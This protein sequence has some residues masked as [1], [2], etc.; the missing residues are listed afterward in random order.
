MTEPSRAEF[1]QK[2]TV[3]QQHADLWVHIVKDFRGSSELSREMETAAL[4]VGDV[5]A[6]VVQRHM[7]TGERRSA[8]LNKC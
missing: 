5:V 7:R 8:S 1:A 2:E 4:K 3:K 6:G